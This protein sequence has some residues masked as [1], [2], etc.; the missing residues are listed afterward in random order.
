MHRGQWSFVTVVLVGSL[1]GGCQR[2]T[3]RTEPLPDV[4]IA[5]PPERRL[6]VPV[7]AVRKVYVDG[8]HVGY[9]KVK[10][11]GEPGDEQIVTLVYDQAF[12]LKGFI[13]ESGRTFLLKGE[14]LQDRGHHAERKGVQILLNVDLD[15]NFSYEKMDR[16]RNL[17]SEEG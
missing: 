8:A 6:A 14:A 17:E 16:P 15:A 11:L 7:I 2:D 13:G 9:V 12:E 4:Q 3:Q 10:D 5:T 1:V